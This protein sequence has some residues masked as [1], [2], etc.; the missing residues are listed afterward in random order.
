[1]GLA[2]GLDERVAEE[3]VLLSFGLFPCLD[4]A[5]VTDRE[6][7]SSPSIEL[8]KPH[9]AGEC[10]GAFAN[11]KLASPSEVHVGIW[12]ALFLEQISSLSSPLDLPVSSRALYK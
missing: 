11:Q 3:S 8:A 6:A 7:L 4:G 1:L 5:G 12:K 10:S 9:G 2:L